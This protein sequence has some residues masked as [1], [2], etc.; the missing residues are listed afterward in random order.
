MNREKKKHSRTDLHTFGSFVSTGISIA[1]LTHIC[2]FYV[3]ILYLFILAVL[4]SIQW[5]RFLFSAYAVI[6]FYYFFYLLLFLLIVDWNCFVCVAGKR[7][8]ISIYTRIHIFQSKTSFKS[9]HDIS[10][11]KDISGRN[12]SS[13]LSAALSF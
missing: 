10:P 9:C 2:V 3:C 7:Q 5:G 13:S 8:H 1:I 12:R 11:G 4:T 6:Y